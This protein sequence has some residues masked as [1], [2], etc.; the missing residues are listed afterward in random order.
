MIPHCVKRVPQAG[1]Y[2]G[3]VMLHGRCLAVHQTR[4]G[5]NLSSER[6][7]DALVAKANSQD[8]N[9]RAEF[10]NNAIANAGRLRS[11][12]SGRQANALG[13]KRMDRVER[14][15]IVSLHYDIAT[16]LAKILDE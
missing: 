8:R 5:S 15:L 12:G 4:R 9:R 3:A 13:S 7:S 2:A 1:K 16:Q 11:P 6:R 14:N 10:L